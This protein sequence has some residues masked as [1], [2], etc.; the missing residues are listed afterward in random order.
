[1]ELFRYTDTYG[2]WLRAGHDDIVTVGFQDDIRNPESRMSTSWIYLFGDDGTRF[3]RRAKE[4]GHNVEVQDSEM[5]EVSTIRQM[6][7]YTKEFLL[8][9]PLPGRM[10]QMD[11]SLWRISRVSR[12]GGGRIFIKKSET[13]GATA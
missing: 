13:E 3:Q 5:A 10:L 11:K 2:T 8:F 1:M 7:P 6:S 9:V 12:R 4:L